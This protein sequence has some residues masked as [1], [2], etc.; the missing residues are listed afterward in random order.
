MRIQSAS[1]WAESWRRNSSP[2]CV[3]SRLW[4]IARSFLCFGNFRYLVSP[5]RAL[6][7]LR[8]REVTGG[9]AGLLHL[10]TTKY[11]IFF[12]RKIFSVRRI[13]VVSI[14]LAYDFLCVEFSG[15]TIYV[16]TIFACVQ[17]TGHRVSIAKFKSL[18]LHGS[19]IFSISDIIEVCTEM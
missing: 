8:F 14:A 16:R 3:R 7:M 19:I 4:G 9:R 12:L 10:R 13:I 2:F 1:P 6:C 15:C 17:F 11:Y 5:R 18:D